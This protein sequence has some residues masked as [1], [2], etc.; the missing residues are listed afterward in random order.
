MVI[1]V[2]GMHITI[3]GKTRSMCPSIRD[4][5]LIETLGYPPIAVLHIGV[6]FHCRFL[7]SMNSGQVA[8]KE[9]DRQTA[10][11][12]KSDAYEPNGHRCV[13]KHTIFSIIFFVI[14]RFRAVWISCFCSLR[15]G[16]NVNGRTVEC[17]YHSPRLSHLHKEIQK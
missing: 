14:F 2:L 15:R 13:Q 7:S 11:W 10:K 12:T 3:K 16:Y 6:I 9:M 4:V 5:L 8:N 1:R 17:F